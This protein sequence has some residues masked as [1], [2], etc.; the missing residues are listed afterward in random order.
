MSD[1]DCDFTDQE[2]GF[3]QKYHVQRLDDPTGKHDECKYFVLDLT[4]GHDPFVAPAL[5]AYAMACRVEYPLL[6]ED[7]LKIA[8]AMEH[9][10]E[11]ESTS[12]QEKK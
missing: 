3:Y 11:M 6:F 9:R 4:H 12:S 5:R 7:L 2:R 8:A 1:R 10:V